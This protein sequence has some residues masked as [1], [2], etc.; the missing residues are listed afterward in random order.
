MSIY[1]GLST[2]DR[3]EVRNL[4]K[5]KGLEVWGFVLIGT[6]ITFSVKRQ[7]A[8]LVELLLKSSQPPTKKG[9]WVW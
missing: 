3:D 1:D 5:S 6:D 2:G 9:W 7:Q 8:A 4:L